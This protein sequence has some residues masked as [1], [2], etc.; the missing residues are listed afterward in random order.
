MTKPGE[1]RERKRGVYCDRMTVAPLPE[2][3]RD[4]GLSLPEVFQPFNT[5]Q[6]IIQDGANNIR[7]ITNFRNEVSVEPS[8]RHSWSSGT[9]Y[10][11]HLEFRDICRPL[12]S[13]SCV[14]KTSQD[15]S[16]LGS[17]HSISEIIEECSSDDEVVFDDSTSGNSKPSSLAVL[18][19]EDIDEFVRCRNCFQKDRTVLVVKSDK[20]PYCKKCRD[21]LRN[22]NK[23][24]N[25]IPFSLKEL[26][27]T[28]PVSS[29]DF[30][31]LSTSPP[32][33]CRKAS[34]T[35]LTTDLPCI[36]EPS[37]GEEGT[38]T[39][40]LQL[41]VEREVHKLLN[42]GSS[43]ITTSN[44]K[45][46]N[47]LFCHHPATQRRKNCDNDLDLITAGLTSVMIHK[48]INLIK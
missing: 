36:E 5:S 45:S 2:N 48:N 1:D 31:T 7:Y 3:K 16:R 28:L 23:Y 46:S 6:N 30:M 10:S 27:K 25:M 29:C 42:F 4:R 22:K 47:N 13:I 38:D 17:S 43:S 37:A 12:P 8:R 20:Y 24:G 39:K 18:P 9:N 35:E 44:N 15:S 21:L 34:V 26:R 14:R 41:I 11:P 33:R 40:E 32:R 19:A